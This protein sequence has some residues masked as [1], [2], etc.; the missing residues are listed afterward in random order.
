MLDVHIP[1]MRKSI[2]LDR[3]RNHRLSVISWTPNTKFLVAR[4]PGNKGREVNSMLFNAWIYTTKTIQ[5]KHRNYGIYIAFTQLV[6]CWPSDSNSVDGWIKDEYP[7]LS[8]L[9]SEEQKYIQNLSCAKNH[10]EKKTR[11]KSSTIMFPSFSHHVPIIFPSCSHHFHLM[12][13]SCSH[14]VP[15]I[16]PSFSPWQKSMRI[17]DVISFQ[18]PGSSQAIANRRARVHLAL[19]PQKK[20]ADFTIKTESWAELKVES[21]VKSAWHHDV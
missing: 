7:P 12:P 2:A 20:T 11:K 13:R 21:K 6:S 9:T 10:N 19:R 18:L 15:I 16:F 8:K 14:H 5:K 17:G 3:S 1:V 4:A